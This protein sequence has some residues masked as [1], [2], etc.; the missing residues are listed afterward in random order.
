MLYTRLISEI[1]GEKIGFSTLFKLLA[2]LE[3]KE[4]SQ[5]KTTLLQ[6]LF[7]CGNENFK[8]AILATSTEMD[9]LE[10]GGNDIRLFG[11]GFQI[12][13]KGGKCEM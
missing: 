6:A 4:H 5:I 9:Q 12:T 8:K 10:A 7:L 2:S 11:I 3:E 13:K 1:D